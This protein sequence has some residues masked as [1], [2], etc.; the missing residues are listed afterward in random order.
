MTR[1]KNTLKQ[2]YSRFNNFQNI[3]KFVTEKIKK[4]KFHRPDSL[5]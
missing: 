3:I 1:K 5:E 2:K 4:I